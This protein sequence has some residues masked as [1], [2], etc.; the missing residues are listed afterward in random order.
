[1]LVKS[2]LKSSLLFF[3]K[4][5][6]P[7][8]IAINIGAA[9]GIYA[10]L[11]QQLAKKC[12]AF[13]PNP[14]SHAALK[15]ALPGV[16]SFQAAVSARDGYTILRVPVVNGIPYTGWATIEPNNKLAELP[17]HDIRAR[18]QRRNERDLHSHE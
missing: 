18:H 17:A 5:V 11:L 7:Q 13:E 10:L 9:E 15:R 8:R 4:Q 16:E 2:V 1:M 12:I 3:E 6:D 14:S